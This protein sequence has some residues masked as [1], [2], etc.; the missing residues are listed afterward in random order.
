MDLYIKEPAIYVCTLP[1]TIDEY[2][3]MM[4]YVT[5]PALLAVFI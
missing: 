1:L 4:Q 2:L 5:R 3:I